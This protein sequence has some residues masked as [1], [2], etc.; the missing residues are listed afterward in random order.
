MADSQIKAT[1]DG[2]GNL[3]FSD[4]NTEAVSVVFETTGLLTVTQGTRTEVTNIRIEDI[5]SVTFPSELDLT[6]S[7]SVEFT[8]QP[9]FSILGKAFRPVVFGQDTYYLPANS[10]PTQDVSVF[11]VKTFSDTQIEGDTK[12]GFSIYTSTSLQTLAVQSEREVVLNGSDYE[13]HGFNFGT[14]TSA[15]SLFFKNVYAGDLENLLTKVVV[16]ENTSKYKDIFLAKTFLD[17]TLTFVKEAT[18]TYITLYATI[19]SD[20]TGAPPV[21][22]YTG[23]Q[24]TSF[25]PMVEQNVIYDVPPPTFEADLNAGAISFSGTATGPVNLYF[26]VSGQLFAT[27]EG[28]EASNSGQYNLN[29]IRSFV[30]TG[31]TLNASGVTDASLFDQ[32]TAPGTAVLGKVFRKIA[33]ESIELYAPAT[34]DM[35]GTPGVFAIKN[36]TDALENNALKQG[37][38]IYTRSSIDVVTSG[39]TVDIDTRN[40]SDLTIYGTT[41]GTGAGADLLDFIYVEES[42]L[43]DR[44]EQVLIEEGTEAYSGLFLDKSYITLDISITSFLGHTKKVRLVNIIS[45]DVPGVPPAGLYEPPVTDDFVTMLSNNI[46]Y[47]PPPSLYLTLVD[48]ELRIEGT[49]I[50][51]IELSVT[52]AGVV[53]AERELISVELSTPIPLT[54]I[55]SVSVSGSPTFSFSGTVDLSLFD[56]DSVVGIKSA[57]KTFREVLFGNQAIY[58]PS[59]ITEISEPNVFVL[60][61]G[62]DAFSSGVR[63]S[64]FSFYT[65]ESLNE[66]TSQTTVKIDGENDSSLN[67]YGITL[68]IG[69]GSDILR[70]LNVAEDNLAN[71]LTG[72]TVVQSASNYSSVFVDKTFIDLSFSFQAL[73]GADKTVTLHDVISDDVEGVPSAGVYDAQQAQALIP[74]LSPNLEFV[75]PPEFIIGLIDNKLSFGGNTSGPIT[76]NVNEFGTIVSASQEGTE[77]IV[78]E[79]INLVD[80][81]SAGQTP[82]E[83]SLIGQIDGS[84]F[85]ATEASNPGSSIEV[86][87]GLPLRYIAIGTSSHFLPA[88]V[89][90]LAS[91][92]VFVLKNTSGAF[93]DGIIKTELALFDPLTLS[94]SGNNTFEVDSL[95]SRVFTVYGVTLGGEFV[96]A[97]QF[98]G[99]DNPE[100]LALRV[101]S[102]NVTLSSTPYAS[103]FLDKT[104]LNI[105]IAFKNG[106]NIVLEDAVSSDV[107]GAPAPGSYSS[108]PEIE[109][110]LGVFPDLTCIPPDLIWRE[111]TVQVP[112]VGEQMN[113]LSIALPEHSY[114]EVGE[115][116]TSTVEGNNYEYPITFPD[117]VKPEQP[118]SASWHNLAINSAFEIEA[119]GRDLYGEVGNVPT[120]RFK[121]VASGQF[122]ALALTDS[123]SIVGWG[124][125]GQNQI[126]NKPLGEGYVQVAAGSAHSMALDSNGVIRVW[127]DNTFKQIGGSPDE[128]TAVLNPF[129]KIAASR[130]QSA[131]ITYQNELYVW[132]FDGDGH[133]S[134]APSGYFLDVD[135]GEKHTIALRTD[136]TLVVWGEDSNGEVSDTPTGTFKAIAAGT[137]FCGAL[138]DD[139]TIA[140]WG[141]LSF[142]RGLI[143]QGPFDYIEAGVGHFI[144]MNASGK[145]VTWGRDEDSQ[146]TSTPIHSNFLTEVEKEWESD[147]IP[148]GLSMDGRPRS[149]F[150]APCEYGGYK[151][152]LLDIRNNYLEFKVFEYWDPRFHVGTNL[153]YMSDD[154]GY[155]QRLRSSGEDSLMMFVNPRWLAFFSDLSSE[156]KPSFV[157]CFEIEKLMEMEYPGEF[158]LF[159]WVQGDVCY[160]TLQ[161]KRIGDMSRN[162]IY[163]YS[164]PRDL[165]NAV[166]QNASSFAV[167]SHFQ[168]PTFNTVA[169]AYIG[170]I[171][172]RRRRSYGGGYYYYYAVNH[173]SYSGEW[174]LYLDD[175]IPKGNGGT[176]AISPTAVCSD[177]ENAHVRGRFFGLKLLENKIGYSRDTIEIPVDE[178][179]FYD[180]SSL[181][182]TQHFVVRNSRGGCMA[183]PL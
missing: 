159:A 100:R 180:L 170:C 47:T 43:A 128:A 38:S 40:N 146:V 160:G 152:V 107:P 71:R 88:L 78:D 16:A 84:L 144:V 164:L 42:G 81:H 59:S 103:L 22:T 44:I 63:K 156:L 183:L 41:L 11:V 10:D 60:K 106:G 4:Y 166:G 79:T 14:G 163:A 92:N 8:W 87:S 148:V 36:G 9:S 102:V 104:F 86:K 35:L 26:D 12:Q 139:G 140:V 157:G 56:A 97:F 101:S 17:I 175:F 96:D 73:E 109:M 58:L 33:A 39:L 3:S 75:P 125:D 145:L 124:N 111:V 74:L 115:V 154:L 18:Q 7:G 30:D 89:D 67:V 147:V 5:R 99:V 143:P 54:D 66:I 68:G 177:P 49:A 6:V 29:D 133:V 48:N 129:V 27:R 116:T 138:R 176:F 45:D 178:D 105:E 169:Y 95:D 167:M 25:V 15:D 119:W 126:T 34:V 62:T 23:Q 1:L 83:V 130:Y 53:G 153:A 120:G 72:A 32:G 2:T 150:R 13:F 161:P 108:V 61:N 19:A 179:G 134:K 85:A 112:V 137:N 117:I 174:R 21:G 155:T 50:G 24:A 172:R 110:L 168:A 132:G 69:E 55:H 57:G 142:D 171:R 65:V 158:P 136:G 131:A 82:N 51:D 70:L 114:V 121:A 20:A 181:D 46:V 151:Y 77:A 135:C 123:G 122:H 165:R 118:I 93:Q 98:S 162:E 91:E 90:D 37:F 64:G 76:I 52:D 94:F 80:V 113:K 31:I 182:L 141:D 149:C 173:Q 127:G 28:V